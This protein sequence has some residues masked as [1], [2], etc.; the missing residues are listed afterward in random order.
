M[1]RRGRNQNSWPNQL[2][3]GNELLKN[4]GKPSNRYSKREH[5]NNVDFPKGKAVSFFSENLDVCYI[6]DMLL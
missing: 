3:E 2:L 6:I 5:N 4:L 1:Q